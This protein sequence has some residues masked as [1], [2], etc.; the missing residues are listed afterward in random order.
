LKQVALAAMVSGK[1]STLATDIS[2][3]VNHGIKE[4]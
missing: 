4:G 3:E 1:L 2:L